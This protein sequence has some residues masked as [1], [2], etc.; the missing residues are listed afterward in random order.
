M[1]ACWPLQMDVS[2]KAVLIALADNANDAGYCWPS[3]E[4]I[5]KRTC[6]HRAN[7][8]KA[9]ERLESMRHISVDRSNGRHSTY[10]VTPNLDLFDENQSR[11]A[12][13]SGA[14][15]VAER[16]PSRSATGD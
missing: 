5:A 8:I 7:V 1:A 4:T 11:S 2:A 16:Y 13:G 3:I 15:P 12:T 6:L 10:T 14:R 9:I